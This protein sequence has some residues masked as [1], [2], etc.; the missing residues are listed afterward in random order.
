[1]RCNRFVFDSAVKRHQ[2][3]Q[4]VAKPQ[5]SCLKRGWALS[6][7]TPLCVL[8]ATLLINSSFALFLQQPNK[9]ADILLKRKMGS[10]RERNRGICLP[11]PACF[12]EPTF[13]SQYTLW[14]IN[15]CLSNEQY[16]WSHW[17]AAV[18]QESSC[19][20][21]SDAECFWGKTNSRNAVLQVLNCRMQ[22]IN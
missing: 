2:W 11:H 10:G 7:E 21:H 13:P 1:M 18:Y 12:L 22:F 4:K 20:K 5:R 19:F 16:T 9:K 3:I 6:A 17:N 14:E 8:H 15:L